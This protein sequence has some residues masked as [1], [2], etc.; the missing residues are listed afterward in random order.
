MIVNIGGISL[1]KS[2]QQVVGKITTSVM[3]SVE[4]LELANLVPMHERIGGRSE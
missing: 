2:N 1:L 4:Q 3:V